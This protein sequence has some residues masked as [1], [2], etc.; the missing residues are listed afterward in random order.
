MNFKF[1]MVCSAFRYFKTVTNFENDP[2]C[3]VVCGDDE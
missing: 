3:C 2:K 1:C